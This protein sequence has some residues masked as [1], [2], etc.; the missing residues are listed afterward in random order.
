MEKVDFL[1]SFEN[2][3]YQTL[4]KNTTSR[5]GTINPWT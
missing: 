1:S 5:G 3:G 2:F 4:H